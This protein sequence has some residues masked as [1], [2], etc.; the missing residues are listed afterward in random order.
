M[1]RSKRL[2]ALLLAGMLTLSAVGCSMSSDSGK[3][4]SN[5][6]SE[7][8]EKKDDAKK[9]EKEKPSPQD[10]FYDHVNFDSLKEMEIPYGELYT[11]L[12]DS[13]RFTDQVEDIIKEIGK[14]SE[15]YADGSN[16]QL[17]HDVYQQYLTYKE[18]VSIENDIMDNCKKILATEN[19]QELFKLWGELARTLSQC[20]IFS[21]A[22]SRT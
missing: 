22:R 19:V 9:K 21:A 18:N 17:I 4:D 3:T 6:V 14:S 7:S 5:T 12:Y 1:Q 20:R 11:D 8:D 15:D 16:E 10:D 2:F 13:S